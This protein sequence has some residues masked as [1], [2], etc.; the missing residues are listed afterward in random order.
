MRV[1]VV[2]GFQHNAHVWDWLVFRGWFYADLS[3]V[4]IARMRKRLRQ[5]GV[6]PRF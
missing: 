4:G 5:S 2:R 6:K 3:E 1:R